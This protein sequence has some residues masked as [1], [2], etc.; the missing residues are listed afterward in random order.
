M[1]SSENSEEGEVVSGWESERGHAGSDT[2]Q[3]KRLERKVSPD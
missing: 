1:G 3:I 2:V